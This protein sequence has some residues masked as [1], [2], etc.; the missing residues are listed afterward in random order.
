[1]LYFFCGRLGHGLNECMELSGDC[2]PEKKFGTFLRASPWKVSVDE[3]VSNLGR[4]GR[5]L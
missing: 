4:R 3:E 2:T 5:S 1:M